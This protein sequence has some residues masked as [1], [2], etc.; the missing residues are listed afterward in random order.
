MA[1]VESFSGVRG[2]YGVDIDTARTKTYV[3][4][5][6]EL[7]GPGKIVVGRDTRPSST[8]LHTAALSVLADVIDV[9]V[10]SIPAVQ[11]VVRETRAVGGVMITASHNEPEYNGLK[12]LRNDGALLTPQDMQRV[13][14][15]AKT[16]TPQRATPRVTACDAKRVYAQFLA[17]VLA[18]ASVVRH[19]GFTVLVDFNGGAACGYED[20]LSSF[21]VNVTTVHNTPGTFVRRVEPNKESLAPLTPLLSEHNAMFA[22][23]FD[24]DADRVE[25]VLPER[26]VSGNEVLALVVKEILT[27]LPKGQTVVVNDATSQVVEAVAKQQGARVIECPVG[28]VN[29][30]DTMASVG[31]VVGGEGSSS[32]AVVMPSRCRDGLMSLIFVLKH[33]ARTQQTLQEAV[34]SLP[35]FVSVRKNLVLSKTQAV[36]ARETFIAWGEQS[37]G[38]VAT[39]DAVKVV[40]EDSWAWMR[41]SQTESGVVRIICDAPTRSEAESLLDRA[42]SVVGA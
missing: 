11:C 24:C 20:I 4:A 17:R 3:S 30:V 9:G 27:E 39:G 1:L 10:A 37:G 31:A 28:E 29:V 14:A 26:L 41:T 13:I 35:R 23:G 5:L 6:Q 16:I 40:F 38:R 32:G 12:L 36:R 33:L 34:A 25:L 18:D 42:C 8:D 19:A 21:G 2:V 22:A 7:L 15:R